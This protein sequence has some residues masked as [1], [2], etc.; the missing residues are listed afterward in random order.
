MRLSRTIFADVRSDLTFLQFLNKFSLTIDKLVDFS[1]PPLH[2]YQLGHRV[3][4][5]NARRL[6]SMPP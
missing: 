5:S 4:L 3:I 1:H 2:V 6:H